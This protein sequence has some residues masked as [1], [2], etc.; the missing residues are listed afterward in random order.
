[1]TCLSPI[2]SV[3]SCTCIHDHASLGAN[4]KKTEQ[5]S[6]ALFVKFRI[7][8]TSSGSGFAA[9]SSARSDFN[10]HHWDLVGFNMSLLLFCSFASAD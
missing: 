7:E 2:D 6:W 5:D 4:P 1:M 8:G 9:C 10:E 3:P